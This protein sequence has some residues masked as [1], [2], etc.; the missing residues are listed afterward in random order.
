M[1]LLLIAAFFSTNLLS[2]IYLA[3]IAVGMAAPLHARCLTWRFCVLPVLAVIVVEQYSLYIGLPPPWDGRGSG[4][5][6]RH[7]AEAQQPSVKVRLYTVLSQP[8]GNTH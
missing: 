1:A 5:L 8:L 6:G 3:I 7:R 4:E 2:L